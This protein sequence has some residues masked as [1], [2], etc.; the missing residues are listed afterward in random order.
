MVRLFSGQRVWVPDPHDPEHGMTDGIVVRRN[1]INEFVRVDIVTDV[2]DVKSKD[3]L[4]ECFWCSG[5]EGECGCKH[6]RGGKG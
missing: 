6:Q 1:E 5:P 4:R 3:I 2:I